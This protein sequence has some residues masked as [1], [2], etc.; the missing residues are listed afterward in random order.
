MTIGDQRSLTIGVQA[1]SDAVIVLASYLQIPD[2]SSYKITFGSNE[3]SEVV[4]EKSG[5][6]NV[7][8]SSSRDIL[9]CDSITDLWVSWERGMISAGLGKTIHQNTLASMFDDDSPYDVQAAA[10]GAHPSDRNT[11]YWYLGDVDGKLLHS[12]IQSF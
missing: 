10:F 8:F 2:S 9:S 6:E 12:A 11:T 7:T 1:C 4:I 5:S 3:N